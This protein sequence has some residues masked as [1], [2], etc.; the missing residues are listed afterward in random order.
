M[1]KTVI[2]GGTFIIAALVAGFGTFKSTER[3]TVGGETTIASPVVTNTDPD[4]T[5]TDL[6]VTRIT[7]AEGQ[8]ILLNTEVTEESMDEVLGQLQSLGGKRAYLVISS[9]G[10]SVFAGNRLVSYLE[11]TD[12]DVQTVCSQI[13][14]SMAF[15]IFEAGK[16]RW[17]EGHSMLMGH[18]ASGGAQ[19]SIPN[20]LSMLNAIQLMMDRMDANIARRAKIQY[21][22]FQVSILKNLWVETPD[23]IKMGL[24]DGL[25][26]LTYSKN[27]VGI[28]NT[29][30]ILKQKGLAGNKT[31][32]ILP[33]IYEIH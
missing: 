17:M 12:Q 27:D 33:F 30:E 15:H 8:V 11:N 26:Q 18:P 13:C 3:V 23:A 22:D 5:V 32:D 24:A 10:G 28:F 16:K 29:Q 20:M 9:P 6:K 19:G 31:G 4:L 7:P 21:K 2:I 25:V 1:N 14:A